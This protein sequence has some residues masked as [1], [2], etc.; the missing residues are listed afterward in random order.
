M[1]DSL[2]FVCEFCGGSEETDGVEEDE[3]YGGGAEPAEAEEERTVEG[4]TEFAEVGELVAKEFL[5]DHQPT[6][7]EQMKPP[8]GRQMLEER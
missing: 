1:L 5:I 8:M 2:I 7:S 6:K 3:E 4:E